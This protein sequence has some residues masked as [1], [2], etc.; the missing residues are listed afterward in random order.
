VT[1]LVSSGLLSRQLLQSISSVEASSNAATPATAGS[2]SCGTRRATSAMN[3]FPGAM[4]FTASMNWRLF[5]F[6]SVEVFPFVFI[7]LMSFIFFDGWE[8]WA[9]REGW[10]L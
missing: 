2:M 9:R 8:L 1:G 5:W 7:G 3:L 4:S 10:E 6:K